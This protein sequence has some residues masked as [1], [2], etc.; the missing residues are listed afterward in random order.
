MINKLYT[1][2]QREIDVRKE[3]IGKELQMGEKYE[4][5]LDS[6]RKECNKKDQEIDHL[7]S[8]LNEN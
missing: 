6:V 7:K 8:K 3:N 4:G 5:Q 2:L 1:D